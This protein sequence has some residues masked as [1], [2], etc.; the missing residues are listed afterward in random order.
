MKS[1]TKCNSTRNLTNIRLMDIIGAAV[2][3]FL[4]GD[5]VEDRLVPAKKVPHFK[6]DPCDIHK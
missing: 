4:A 3:I 5:N 6:L 2:P 1:L